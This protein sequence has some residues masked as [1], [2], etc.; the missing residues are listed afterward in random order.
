M[1]GY[2]KFAFVQILTLIKP[3]H[4]PGN[5][6]YGFTLTIVKSRKSLTAVTLSS[7]IAI[8]EAI[9]LGRR[10][11]SNGPD[12]MATMSAWQYTKIQGGLENSLFLNKSVAAQSKALPKGEVLVEIFFAA[13]NPA[14][15]NLSETGLIRWLF[16]KTPATPGHDFCGRIVAVHE[17]DEDIREGQLVFGALS[18]LTQ[19][20]T[21]G[22]LTVVPGFRVCTPARRCG[23]TSRRCCRHS[24][25]DRI[26]GASTWEYQ[27]GIET[28]HQWRQRWLRNIWYTVFAKILGAQ[29]T[30]T[31]STA[32]V[33]L[34]RQL[35]AD[36]VLGYKQV[37]II[38]ELE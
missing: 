27:K 26:S 28:V 3:H 8:T 12:N 11:I 22:Q 15:Y 33:E 30:T 2:Q 37:D 5:C 4:K 24:R 35:G 17:S 9:V 19:P 6:D 25:S 14:D 34:C 7:S 13:L 23:G 10:I 1:F 18:P 38:S 20:G 36:R 29:V 31:C 16:L 32:N 21:L